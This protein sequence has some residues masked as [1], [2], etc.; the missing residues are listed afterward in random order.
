MALRMYH[1][2]VGTRGNCGAR[3]AQNTKIVA[4]VDTFAK[5]ARDVFAARGFVTVLDLPPGNKREDFDAFLEA[6]P[7]VNAVVLGG[8]PVGPREVALAP[9]LEVVARVGVG[10]DAIDIPALAPRRIPLMTAGTANS[11]SVAE[12][13]FHLIFALIKHGHAHDRLVRAGKWSESRRSHAPG[14]IGGKTLLVVGGG[15]IGSR[16]IKRALAM[17]M[18]VLLFDPYLRPDAIEAMG[19][20]PVMHLDDALPIA[21]IVTLHCPRTPETIG[22]IDG[23]RL[24]LMKPSALLINT[25][26]GGL[27]D[28]P[29]L[30]AALSSGVIAG[31]GLDVLAEEPPPLDH[32]LFKLDNVVL[33]PHMAGVTKE[34]VERMSLASAVNVL[35]VFDGAPIVD[36]VIN[37]DVLSKR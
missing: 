2:G 8:Q 12:E 6:N 27:V 1:C 9:A 10:Y 19:A 16:V 37:K 32:P 11:V 14:D 26:R 31:A 20:S 36:N 25:A 13:A 3:M 28:E 23:R 7:G 33:A 29:A 34:A 5:A 21:D 15:R 18:D 4:V 22:L 35:S 24:A 17:E 30:F